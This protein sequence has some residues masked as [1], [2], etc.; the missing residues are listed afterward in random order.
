MPQPATLGVTFEQSQRVYGE[1]SAVLTRY[2]DLCQA[3]AYSPE[4][5]SN[6]NYCLC[7]L[8]ETQVLGRRKDQGMQER[9]PSG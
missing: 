6:T 7:D 8:T 9:P 2:E 1:L 4:D 3:P 5:K